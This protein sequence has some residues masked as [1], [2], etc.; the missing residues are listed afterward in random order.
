MIPRATIDEKQLCL[1]KY[2]L[3]QFYT[4]TFTFAKEN[5]QTSAFILK[6]YINTVHISIKNFVKMVTKIV[7]EN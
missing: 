4:L 2:D 1:A 7:E 5:M 6:I 3:C